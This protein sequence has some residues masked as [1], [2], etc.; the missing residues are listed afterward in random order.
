MVIIFVVTNI[1]ISIY[2]D[3]VRNPTCMTYLHGMPQKA[4][5]MFI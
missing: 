2:D 3:F 4:L 1:L 5:R